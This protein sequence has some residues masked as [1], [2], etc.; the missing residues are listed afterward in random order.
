MIVEAPQSREPVAIRVGDWLYVGS[1]AGE[2]SGGTLE[3]QTTAAFER[4]HALLRAAGATPADIV[5]LRTYYIYDGPDG[6]QVTEYWERMTRVRLRYLALLGPAATAIRVQGVP[7]APLVIAVDALVDFGRQRRRLMPADSWDWSVPTPFSQG[8]LV[9]NRVIVGGQLSADR[10]GKATSVGD[11]V[12]Q[13]RN[14]LEFIRLVLLEA[15]QD[16]SHVTSLRICYQCSEDLGA[17]RVRLGK[18]LTIVQ[19][20]LAP[21]RPTITAI[22]VNLLY[23]GLLLEI[24]ATAASERSIAHATSRSVLSSAA[25]FP[26]A[27]RSGDTIQVGGVMTHNRSDLTQEVAECF[28]ILESSLADLGGTLSDLVKITLFRCGS[29]IDEGEDWQAIRVIADQYLPRPGPVRTLL[30]VPGLPGEGQ[31]F[32]LDAVA[33]VGAFRSHFFQTGVKHD[34]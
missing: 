9:G 27:R 22:G 13:T 12:A 11:I 28:A 26:L 5:N 6:R 15:A 23:E 20:A 8:W 30:T 24:D 33:H 16:W 1:C 34:R 4:L 21:A 29:T 31:R 17:S 2:S 7:F 19:A 32:Q 3:A 18:I 10:Q 25:A 14:T